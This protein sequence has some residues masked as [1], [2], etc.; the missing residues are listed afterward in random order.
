MVNRIAARFAS[1]VFT[2]F[3]GVLPSAITVGQILSDDIVNP[4]VPSGHLSRS[5][6]GRENTELPAVFVMGGSQGSRTLYE[7][8][9][10]LLQT[11][12]K[13]ASGFTF[14]ISLGKLNAELKS[15]F[16]QANVHVFDFLSQKE[17]GELYQRSD[18]C[19]VR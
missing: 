15:L 9:A 10:Q 14:F 6:A 2:G 5:I 12:P 11:N 19:L 13:I 17:M 16:P 7:T 18:F 8:F 4:S 1:A 3:D